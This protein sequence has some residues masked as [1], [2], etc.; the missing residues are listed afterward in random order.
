MPVKALNDNGEGSSYSVARGIY[1]AVDHGADVINMS[2]V[3]TII[4]IY[5]MMRLR[6]LTNKELF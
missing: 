3:I 4:R 6:M 5:F 2:L 1:W